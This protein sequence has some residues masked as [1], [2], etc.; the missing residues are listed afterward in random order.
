MPKYPKLAL[1][2]LAILL[3]GYN[4]SSEPFDC[5]GVK[6]AQIS[7][8]VIRAEYVLPKE[9]SAQCLV[10]IEIQNILPSSMCPLLREDLEDPKKITPV[11]AAGPQ[12]CKVLS[13]QT[14]KVILGVISLANKA[15]SKVNLEIF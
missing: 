8:T 1:V 9:T 5:K 6:E 2:F 15:G 14:G 4:S 13:S 11:V 3:V 10:G 12:E 7:A